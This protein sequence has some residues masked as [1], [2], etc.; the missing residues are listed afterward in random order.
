VRWIKPTAERRIEAATWGLLLI[1][2]GVVL[3]VELRE[4]VPAV[5]AGGIL[6]ASA[7][8]QKSMGGEGGLVFWAGGIAFTLSGLNDLTNGRRHIPVLAVVLILFGAAVLGRALAGGRHHRITIVR[9]GTPPD[10]AR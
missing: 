5:V 1:W 9:N 4:G 7:L 2:A 8:I 3:A 10:E 6:L